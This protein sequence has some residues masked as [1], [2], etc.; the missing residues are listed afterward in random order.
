MIHGSH[1]L[2][3]ASISLKRSRNKEISS[4]KI[5][6]ARIEV[7]TKNQWRSVVNEDYQICGNDKSIEQEIKEADRKVP[8]NVLILGDEY[9][10]NCAVRLN[11]LS[12]NS[13]YLGAYSILIYR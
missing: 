5:K 10:R 3:Q 1:R 12:N 2:Q 6:P 7:I 13:T 4:K 8:V 9:A 11:T